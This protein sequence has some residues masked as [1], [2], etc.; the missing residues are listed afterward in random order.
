MKRA[1][2]LAAIPL[3][4]ATGLPL[5]EAQDKIFRAS[6]GDPLA[7]KIERVD[8]TKI[9]V[10]L[11]AGST[12]VER[13]QVA[14]VEVPRPPTLDEAFGAM[15]K[16]RAADAVKTLDPLLQKYRG[17]AQDWIEEATA[18]LGEAAVAAG[19][20]AKARATFADFQRFYPKSR[21]T[22][23]VRAGEAEVLYVDKKNDQALKAFEAIVAAREKE[24]AP[25]EAEAR[26]LGHACLRIGQIY[27]AMKQP[28]KALDSLLRTTTIYW[29]DPA[30]TAEAL[31]ESAGIYETLRNP[32]RARGQLEDLLREFSDS[33]LASKAREKLKS[34]PTSETAEPGKT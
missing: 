3:L 16:G 24:L 33:T 28:E 18:R 27:A 4:A 10:T 1:H 23:S 19:D 15:D 9:Y 21:F 12:T 22:E 20:L 26:V 2:W 6:G 30:A 14:R 11:S 34:L 17:L 29:Q 31:Y 8:D 7:G 32:A 13:S 25:P 5:A